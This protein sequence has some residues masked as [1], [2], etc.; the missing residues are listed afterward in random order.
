MVDVSLY[1]KMQVCAP[2][3]DRDLLSFVERN[4]AEVWQSARAKL[5]ARCKSDDITERLESSDWRAA[6]QRISSDVFMGDKAKVLLSLSLGD[7][8]PQWDFFLN[9]P[10]IVHFQ[11]VY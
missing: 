8:S 3:A 4:W 9:G 6:V 5:E 10:T 11:P 2:E 1:G 7:T